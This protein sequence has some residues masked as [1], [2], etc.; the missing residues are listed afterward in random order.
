MAMSD[1]PGKGREW[2]QA[3]STQTRLRQARLKHSA[4]LEDLDTRT[5]DDDWS[6]REVVEHTIYWERHSIDDLAE[7][8]LKPRLPADRSR[9]RLD[10]ADPLEGILVSAAAPITTGSDS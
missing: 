7:G 5:P 10:V 6:I 2:P 4:C 3:G 1:P 8:K 9:A